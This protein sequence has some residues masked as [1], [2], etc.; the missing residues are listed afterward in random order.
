MCPPAWSWRQTVREQQGSPVMENRS[1]ER[2]GAPAIIA[3]A[4]LAL[5]AVRAEAQSPAPRPRPQRP[6]AAAGASLA[7]APARPCKPGYVW[8][9]A[10]PGDAVCVEPW[11]RDRVRRE[12]AE[13][14]LHALRVRMGQPPE[15]LAGYVFRAALARDFVCVT[16]TAHAQAQDENA[17]GPSRQAG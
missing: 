3:V 6:L 4:A 11:A 10:R 14:P 5:A 7:I 2:R 15:C 17:L 12:N 1:L 9:E 13:A 8:R 16:P